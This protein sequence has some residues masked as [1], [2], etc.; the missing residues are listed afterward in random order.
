[1][2]EDRIVFWN[3]GVLPEHW[4]LERLL[5]KHPS[6][7]FNP[8]L[9]NTFFRAGYIESWGRGIEKINRECREHDIPAPVWDFGMGGLMLTFRANPAHRQ[10]TTLPITQPGLDEKLGKNRV[11]IMRRMR[12]NAKTTVSELAA[13]LDLSRNAIDKNIQI[14]KTQG[15]IRRIGPSK[16]GH[17]EVLTPAANP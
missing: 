9:A 10:L 7:P 8:L 4:T 12:R 17:W 1:V 11:A 15:Y 6:R 5:G 2:Y 13:A 14:L 16:G 3:P